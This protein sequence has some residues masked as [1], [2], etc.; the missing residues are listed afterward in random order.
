[1]M[2]ECY[3]AIDFDGTCVTNHYP[4]I[5]DDIGADPYLQAACALGAKLILLTMRDGDK[6]E[7]AV[8]WF[9]THNVPIWMV[10]RNPESGWS[11][12]PKVY[13]HIYVDDS[14]LMAPMIPADNRKRE[15]MDWDRAGPWLLRRIAGILNQ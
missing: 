11:D 15:H 4:H 13:A 14:G 1:M 5:G 8:G 9:Q 10:N 12:S 2:R 3:V 7:E 6:L